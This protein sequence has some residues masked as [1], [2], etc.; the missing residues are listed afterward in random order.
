MRDCGNREPGRA[1]GRS[2]R[3]KP[4]C[5]VMA[6]R[7]PD[8]AGYAMFRVGEGRSGEGGYWCGF[9]DAKFRHINE[10][11]P[12]FDGAY[13]RDELSKSSFSVALGHR[14]LAIIDLSHF[15]HQPMSSSDRRYWITYNGE[16]YNFRELRERT[17]RGGPRL[18][19]PQRHRGHSPLVGR[20]R[21]GLSADAGR[22][23]RLRRLRPRGERLDA[24]AAIASG[25]SRCTMPWRAISCCSPAKSRASWP[26]GCC[27]R[28]SARRRWS[29][30]SP[31]R[32]PSR[33]RRFSKTSLS[34]SRGSFCN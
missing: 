28:G 26:A 11:L 15:G 2:G 29:S 20:A 17:R 19:H 24:G 32:T 22:D 5:D 23:V 8:D 18:P 33:R 13:C 1:A 9:A 30:I 4:M 7:G 27:G 21:H 6:H 10:H 34:C 12:V 25:S 16:I 31:S 3:I 14:R